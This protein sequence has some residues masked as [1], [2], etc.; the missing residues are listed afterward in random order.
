MAQYSYA[1][2]G[3]VEWDLFFRIPELMALLANPDSHLSLEWALPVVA[4]LLG[5]VDPVAPQSY[6]RIRAAAARH[7][8]SRR[9]NFPSPLKERGS[10]GF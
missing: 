5:G 3:L 10:D 7:L 2:R 4:G 8:F 6:G 1:V 9:G